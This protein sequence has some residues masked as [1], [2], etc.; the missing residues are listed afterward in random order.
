MEINPGIPIQDLREGFQGERLHLRSFRV[1]PVIDVVIEVRFVHRDLAVLGV[2]DGEIQV[3][4]AR[5]FAGERVGERRPALAV[6]LRL[7]LTAEQFRQRRLD[8]WIF[9]LIKVDAD[10][11][12]V[13][14][15]GRPDVDHAAGAVHL[16]QNVALRVKGHG[17][18]VDV[19]LR[20]F[21]VD[22]AAVRGG[23]VGPNVV[24]DRLVRGRKA[25]LRAGREGAVFR[26]FPHWHGFEVGRLLLDNAVVEHEAAV[27]VG[28]PTFFAGRLAGAVVAAELLRHIRRIGILG[29]LRQVGHLLE[30]I[31]ERNLVGGAG[32]GQ[33]QAQRRQGQEEGTGAH[34]RS[35]TGKRVEEAL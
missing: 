21:A 26:T 27:G 16:R 29:E 4:A 11:A 34:G 19:A 22:G 12:G 13:A 31:F 15:V 18:F 5:P 30:Q 25:D 9:R 10:V 2:G 35:S 17:V 7:P 24:A 14:G 6:D 28:E 3:V 20:D 8:D 23:G 32:G 33:R 1:R